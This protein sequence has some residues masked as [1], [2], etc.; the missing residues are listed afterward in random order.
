MFRTIRSRL[1]NKYYRPFLF[2]AALG[3]FF[4]LNSALPGLSFAGLL[5]PED[6]LKRADEIRN[7]SGDFKMAVEVETEDGISRFEVQV[8]GKDKSLLL[9]Q[10]PARDKGRNMLMLGKDFYLYLPNLK[11]SMRL[12][13]AQKLSGQVANGDI[14][15]TRW[16]GDYSVSLLKSEG[17]F[18]WLKLEAK[19]S[20]LTYQ[21]IH[22]KVET[23]SGKPI[24]SEYFSVD[25]KVL[26][27]KAQ[28]L[29]FKELAGGMRPGLIEIQDVSGKK[30][31]IK[32]NSMQQITLQDSNFTQG[33]LGSL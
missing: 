27:K 21:N 17:L 25:G 26:L 16:L 33:K 15:R 9:T 19:T 11:R 28:F 7:P 31:K 24:E 13:L 14:A 32:I 20:G 22:L 8:K 1:I 18:S 3:T 29:D 2:K 10:F 6:L 30:S 23:Q 5:G 4:L 12:S